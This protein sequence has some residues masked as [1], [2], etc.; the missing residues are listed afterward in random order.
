MFNITKTQITPNETELLLYELRLLGIKP[1]ENRWLLEVGDEQIV[2]SSLEECKSHINQAIEELKEYIYQCWTDLDR[3]SIIIVENGAGNHGGLDNL[4]FLNSVKKSCLLSCN[5]SDLQPIYDNLRSL[6]N[7][8]AAEVHEELIAKFNAKYLEIKLLHHLII[9]ELYRTKL[10]SRYLK[11]TKLAQI[12][13]PWANLDLPMKERAWEWGADGD[14]EYFQQR[15]QARR[16]QTRYNPE[17]D[18]NG[19]F[20]NWQ[21]LT[22]DPYRFEDMKKDSPYKSRTQLTIASQNTFSAKGELND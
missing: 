11:M 7:I 2:L 13:G 16:N 19:F 1:Q 22:R 3:L 18:A 8:D 4:I 12:S 17:Y 6:F 20:Y 5:F 9:K 14:E 21:D 15:T 10:L